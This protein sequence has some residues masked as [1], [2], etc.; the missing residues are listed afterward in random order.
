MSNFQYFERYLESNRIPFEVVPH[1]HSATSLQS[2]KSAHIRA[3][4][5]AKAV[6]LESD[7]CYLAA[8]VPADR[9]VMLGKLR[10]TLGRDFWL[11]RE[12]SL[13]T[14][15]PDCEA[16]AVPALTQAWGVEMVWDDS[17][18]NMD[19]IY[20]EAGDHEHLLRIRT[21]DLAPMMQQVPHCQFSSP[22]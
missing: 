17:L 7:D 10:Q 3:D 13:G 9:H 5:L 16:G 14:M 15:F 19:A 22:I 21:R 4:Q 2:A 11:A 8:V 20:M 6:I 12:G 1:P 18:M